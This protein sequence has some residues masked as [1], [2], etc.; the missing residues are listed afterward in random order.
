MSFHRYPELIK[1]AL[2]DVKRSNHTLGAGSFGS[3]EE[4]VIKGKRLAGKFYHESSLGISS[5]IGMK[6]LASECQLLSRIHHPN[7][8]DFIGVFFSHSPVPVIVME[9]MSLSL[10]KL[11]NNAKDVE[12]NIKLHILYEVAKGL[13]FLHSNTPPLV[14]RDLTSNNVLLSEDTATVKIADY[15]N[16]LI[17]DPEKA[18]MLL[19]NQVVLSYMPPEATTAHPEFGPPLDIFSFGHLTLYIMLKKFPGNLLA[20]FCPGKSSSVVYVRTELERR[21]HYLDIL[22]DA[23]DAHSP[24]AEVVKRCLEDMPQMRYF[25]LGIWLDN[26][27]CPLAESIV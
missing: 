1:L 7:L 3:V 15:R 24:I 26:G 27:L 20:K 9:H 2:E 16:V 10:E 4:V 23:V 12:L 19:R 8:V 18:K 6:R 22:E 5:D 13:V 17:V 14:H 25:L 11:L 21:Q